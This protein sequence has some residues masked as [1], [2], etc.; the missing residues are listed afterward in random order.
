MN[1]DEEGIGFRA[2]K[3]RNIRVY[4]RSSAVPNLPL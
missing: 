4:L 1:A 3:A 2:P